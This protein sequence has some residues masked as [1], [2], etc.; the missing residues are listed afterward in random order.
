MLDGVRR[1]P[2]ANDIRSYIA[3]YEAARGRSFSKRERQS[4]FAHCVYFIAYGA[5]CTHALEPD[6]TEWEEDTWPYLLRTE[7]AALLHDAIV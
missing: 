3:D 7:G 5:R 2:T 4:L 1:I 6:K